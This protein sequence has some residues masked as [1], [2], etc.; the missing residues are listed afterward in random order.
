[1]A[2]VAARAE[3]EAPKLAS[4]LRLTLARLGRRVRQE[5]AARDEDLTPSRLAAL[6]TL[7]DTGPMTL[8]QLA[9]MEQVSSPSMTRIVAR[10]EELR[11]AEREMS[12]TDR[13]VVRVHITAQGRALLAATRTRRDLFLAR[14]V[15]RL[16]ID[17]RA[18]LARALPI[19][20]KLLE[21]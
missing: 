1:M 5:G 7:D 13:R 20:D 17:E 19:M 14:R 9:A 6:T 4:R 15:Q 8:G 21:D 16:T 11:L 18:T 3:L 10:L 2:Q 12:S